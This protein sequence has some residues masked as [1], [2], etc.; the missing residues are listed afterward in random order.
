[1]D[2]NKN[3]NNLN[4]FSIEN[5]FWIEV[6]S[7]QI[8]FR[9]SSLPKDIH[10]TIAFNEKSKDINLHITRNVS[11]NE[12]TDFEEE[13]PQLR[14]VVIE[15]KLFMDKIFDLF[16]DFITSI[17]QPISINDLKKKYNNEVG[18]ISFDNLE[19]IEG[20]SLSGLYERFKKV[21]QI[22]RKKRLKIKGKIEED[23]LNFVKDENLNNSIFNQ[24]ED[25]LIDYSKPIDGG[26][27]F[28]EKNVMHVIRIYESW[29]IFNQNLSLIEIFRL[30]IEPKTA[31]YLIEKIKREIEIIKEC[32]S[33]TDSEK[34]NYPIRL[35]WN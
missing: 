23:I 30:L 28:T 6:K 25:I 15:K 19:K 14:I 2:E 34:Y 17:L 32:K 7:H 29:Y 27:I 16:L 24:I 13:N 5:L 18:F 22:K 20:I 21:I 9:F 12:K 4:S 33:R 3:T 35:E 10:F 31:D 11:K 8:N 1:M 26:I